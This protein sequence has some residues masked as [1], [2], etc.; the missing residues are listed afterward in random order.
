MK[1]KINDI[2]IVKEHIIQAL[3]QLGYKDPK[4]IVKSH[5][6]NRFSVKLSGKSIGIWDSVKYTFVD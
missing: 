4:P 6:M 2:D 5:G 3:K 1:S